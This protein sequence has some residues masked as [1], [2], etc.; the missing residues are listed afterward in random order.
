MTTE[1]K[2]VPVALLRNIEMTWRQASAFSNKANDVIETGLGQLRALLA[3]P[4]LTD[5]AEPEVVAVVGQT[6]HASPETDVI[7]MPGIDSLPV[8]TELVDRAHVTQLK[9]LLAQVLAESD[10]G[11]PHKLVDEIRKALPATSIAPANEAERPGFEAWHRSKFATRYHTGGPTRDMHNNVRDPNYG[12]PAQQHMWEAWQARAAIALDEGGLG[13]VARER[14]ISDGI[15]MAA[16]HLQQRLTAAEQ[17]N[18][19]LTTALQNLKTAWAASPESISAPVYQA[20]CAA[21]KPTESGAGDAER[22]EDDRWL[23]M[24]DDQERADWNE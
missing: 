7:H 17:R 15:Q 16:N 12:P 8:G 19:V 24:K 1:S 18:A 5:H 2:P 23:Q 9:S 22:K 20:A 3:G 4:V 13:E 6:D 14:E 10:R 21:L 11:L